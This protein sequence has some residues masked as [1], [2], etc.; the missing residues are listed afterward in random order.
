M[1]ADLA[2]AYLDLSDLDLAY[3]YA[4]RALSYA[5]KT[6]SHYETGIALDALAQVETGRGERTAADRHFKKAISIHHKARHQHFEGR[7][8]R[9]YAVALLQWSESSR[10]KSLCFSRHCESFANSTSQTKLSRRKTY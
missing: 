10:A 5:K 2:M 1:Y 3:D 4:Q 9:D 6:D 8:K 7:T